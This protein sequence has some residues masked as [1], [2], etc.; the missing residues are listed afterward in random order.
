MTDTSGL[1]IVNVS[2]ESNSEKSLSYQKKDGHFLLHCANGQYL[3]FE[4]EACILKNDV[5]AYCIPL[6]NA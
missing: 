3:V 5:H 4:K 6:C 1:L 2:A